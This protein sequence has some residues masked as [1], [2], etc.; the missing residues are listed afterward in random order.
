MLKCLKPC[1]QLMAVSMV[2][3]SAR[4]VLLTEIIHA[5]FNAFVK[6]SAGW[7]S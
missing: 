7:F 3:K 2:I 4:F 5:F 1:G 6:C